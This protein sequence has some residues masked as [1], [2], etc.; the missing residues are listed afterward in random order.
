M[1]TILVLAAL[2]ATLAASPAADATPS[3]RFVSKRY[4]YSIVLPAA[5]TSS[6]ASMGWKGGAPFPDPPEADLYDH[7]AA[8]PSFAIAARKLP[9]PTTTLRQWAK[10]YVGA[11]VPSFCIKSP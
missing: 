10:A 4:S 9:T 11:A 7:A 3:K 1:R 8:R 6:P 2:A 5:W